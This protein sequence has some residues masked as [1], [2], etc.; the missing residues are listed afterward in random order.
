MKAISSLWLAVV[1]TFTFFAPCSPAE[2]QQHKNIRIGYLAG[3]SPAAAQYNINAFRQGLLALGYI[4]DK[5]IQIEYRYAEGKLD[6]APT[7]IA[8][9]V[10]LKVDVLVTTTLGGT[11]AA[12]EATKTIPIVTVFAVDPVATGNIDS[13]ARPGGNIT[14]VATLQ[15]DLS[16]K[17]LELL[18]EVVPRLSRVG[19]IWDAAAPGSA[20][21]FKEYEAAA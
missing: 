3:T 16:G 14:G 10:Q 6:R 12:K 21:A 18:R 13:L 1:L 17:R 7:L 5:N 20:I 9:L 19:V 15:R 11:Q 4:E 8:E 2:V